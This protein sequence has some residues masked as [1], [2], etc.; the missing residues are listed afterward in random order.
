MATDRNEKL[1][2]TSLIVFA[3]F[4]IF[5]YAGAFY[6]WGHMQLLLEQNGNF[7][8]KCPG[9]KSSGN[10][11]DEDEE[12]NDDDVVVVCSEQTAALLTC[13]LVGQLT[14]LAGPLLGYVSDRYG[15]HTLT[16]VMGVATVAGLILLVCAVAFPGTG[17]DS[18]LYAAFIL[19][20]IGSTCGGLLTVETGLLF[21]DDIHRGA[22]GGGSVR[23][24]N[25][26]QSRVIALLNALFDAGAMTYLSLWGME[27][28][29]SS[30]TSKGTSH[31]TAIFS[32]YMGFAVLCLGGYTY[33]FRT[34][35]K[36]VETASLCN[37]NKDE[38]GVENPE[39]KKSTETL[40][41]Q[42]ASDRCPH[43]SIAPSKLQSTITMPSHD[44]LSFCYDGDA[45]RGDVTPKNTLEVTEESLP[46]PTMCDDHVQRTQLCTETP[47]TPSSDSCYV[48]IAH[49][50]VP[51]QLK[52]QAYVM[53]CIFYSFHMVSN[54]WTLTTARDFLKHFGDDEYG[55]R[56][57]S[58]FTLMTPVSLLALPFVDVAIHKF[59]FGWA[60]QLVNLLNLAHG[61]IKVSTTNLNVQVL[62]FVFF[63]FFR[64]FLFAVTFTCLPSF[65]NG[66]ATGRGMGIFYVVSGIASFFNIPLANLAVEKQDGD[67]FI[68]NLIF[69]LMTLPVIY[70]T[71]LTDKALVRDRQSYEKKS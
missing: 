39:E 31:T 30:S 58:I 43:E 12:R 55:N 56:Y 42:T 60:L 19:V 1:Q 7:A 46:N 4:S 61:I 53:L 34:V 2:R 71:C 64:C 11:E 48:P 27:K 59:G 65:I 26:T 22:N 33:L 9:G 69:L 35:S 23:A 63:S 17:W 41:I 15:G 44:S 50:P 62:G 14:V 32:A 68:A 51:D 24:S 8:T 3:S 38:D 40:H 10:Y 66:N 20:G 70:V 49:R 36:Q 57:L 16:E 37:A 21:R 13:R 6:G 5:V 54:V 45:S 52:S 18:V 28:V 25:K 47:T 29:S 67:F